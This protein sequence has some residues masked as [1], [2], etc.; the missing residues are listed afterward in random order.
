MNLCLHKL[1][2]P[3]TAILKAWVGYVASIAFSFAA[4]VDAPSTSIDS[5]LRASTS[6]GP[7]RSWYVGDRGAI[8]ATDNGGRKWTAQ[9]SGTSLSLYGVCFE[10]ERS[11]WAVGGE[12]LPY[13]HRSR[14]IVLRTEDGGVRWHTIENASLPRL[15]GIQSLGQGEL[16][17]WGDWSPTY[18]SGLFESHDGGRTWNAKSIPATHIQCAAWLNSHCGIVV[19][20]LSRVHRFDGQEHPALSHIGGD[21]SR[22]ILAVAVNESGWWLVGAHGQVFWSNDGKQWEQKPLPG[23]PLDQQLITIQTIALNG[24]NVW[25]GGMPGNVVW[26]SQNQG[27]SWDVDPLPNH[28]PITSMQ[29]PAQDSVTVGSLAGQILGTRSRGQ[30]WWTLHGSATRVAMLNVASTI[31]S[32]AWD[33]MAYMANETRH[34][35]AGLVVHSQRTYELTDVF[36]DLQARASQAAVLSHL[37]DINI[38]SSFPVG[39]LLNGRRP[40]D[41][42]GYVK[43]N[44]DTPSSVTKRLVMWLRAYRPDVL[45]VDGDNAEDPL[46]YAT[47]EAAHQAR[48][49]ASL[50]DYRCFSPISQIP[51]TAWNISRVM[52]CSTQSRS[53]QAKNRHKGELNYTS[54]TALKSSGQLLSELVLP[55]SKLLDRPWEHE[56]NCRQSDDYYRNYMIV[57]GERG[58]IGKDALLADFATGSQTRRSSNIATKRNLQ[59]LMAS[60]QTEQLRERL[61]EMPGV[62]NARDARWQAALQ[63]WTRNI[64]STQRADLLWELGEG[65]RHRG[66]WGR[67]QA[68]LEAVISEAPS[69]G[70]AELAAIQWLQF[71]SSREVESIRTVSREQE[72]VNELNS[73]RTNQV[74]LSPFQP[75]VIQASH[76]SK[77]THVAQTSIDHVLKLKNHLQLNFPQLRFDPRWLT[78]N[79][80]IERQSNPESTTLHS[81]PSLARL[82]SIQGAVAWEHIVAQEVETTPNT[83]LIPKTRE[84]P[85]LDGRI[86]EGVWNHSLPIRLSSSWADENQAYSEIRLMHDEDFIFLSA[87]FPNIVSQHQ[88]QLAEADFLTIR[89]DTDR[90][91]LSWFEIR[92]DRR[93]NVQER[94]CDMLQWRPHWY[95]KTVDTESGWSLEAAI[96]RSALQ[97]GPNGNEAWGFAFHREIGGISSQSARPTFNDRPSSGSEILLGFER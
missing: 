78:I 16:I 20:R 75:N 38:D 5:T 33:T 43:A 92:L 26:N 25:L 18:Q 36:V 37:S 1:R 81:L 4:N 17:A 91:Y 15:S 62:D 88:T 19:D 44:P 63:T 23:L 28:L 46:I 47:C 73:D 89:I 76:T 13:S 8:L 3:V 14:G 72:M 30:G 40:S 39:N 90:D 52:S 34:H 61:L 57:Y 97:S 87:T 95:F 64:S 29:V 11:G 12:I 45:V 67:W 58:S 27:A 79:A 80:A 83:S 53:P 84:R 22:P 54:G 31:E 2:T 59:T 48:R 68:C 86:D 96:P 77:K 50:P 55:V 56:K 66:Y 42:W 70:V 82:K 35:V 7:D 60:I 74:A 24:K 6:V 69:S 51:E 65:Y 85:R 93:G 10:S 49:L 9:N 32:V 21:P 94:C 41:R 71:Q